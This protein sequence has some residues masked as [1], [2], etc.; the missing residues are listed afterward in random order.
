MSAQVVCF[1]EVMLRLSPPGEQRLARVE[2]LA[3]HVAGAEAD[4]AAD[5]ALLGVRTA[6]V[7]VLPDGPLGER[8]AAELSGAGVGLGHVDRVPGR[9]ALFFVVINLTVDLLYY[10]VD[11]RLRIQPT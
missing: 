1:G 2:A 8:A 10:A 6:G 7:G 9:M 4:I 5:L 3:V 11:P